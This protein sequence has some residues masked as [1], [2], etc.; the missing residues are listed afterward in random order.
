TTFDQD[1]A[2]LASWLAN[3]N[4]VFDPSHSPRQFSGGVGNF[5]YL[6]A[7]DGALAVLRRPPPG[8]RPPGANDMAREFRALSALSQSLPTVPKPIS[9]CEDDSI[10]GAPFLISEFRS[11]R[12]I[13]GAK[14][15]ATSEMRKRV[16]TMLVE[17][18]AELH[19]IDPVKAGADRLGSPEGFAARTVAGW[20]KRAL[21]ATDDA[22]SDLLIEVA[23]WLSVNTPPDSS[24]PCIL[25]NDFKLDNIIV[26][27]EVPDRAVAI[28]DWDMATIGDPLFDLATMLSYWAEAGDPPAMSLLQQIPSAEP[29]FLSRREAT[30]LYAELTGRDM[31]AMNF[32]RG[33]AQFKLA[34]VLLQ[35]HARWRRDPE[36]FSEFEPYAFVAEGLLAFARDLIDERIV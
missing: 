35:L 27:P 23:D 22:P 9:L 13:R 7:V 30:D 28:L 6:I 3:N 16:S 12:V 15:E 33:L 21:V 31:S 20:R 11:G 25:H 34:I 10:L 26:D 24:T 17:Q 8:R 32:F 2:A 29:G 18:L 19:A 14:F 5:N 36:K 1:W 4:M